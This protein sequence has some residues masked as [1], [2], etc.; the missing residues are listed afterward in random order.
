M[1]N[2]FRSIIIVL[3]RWLLIW[4]FILL[5]VLIDGMIFYKEV[6]AEIM[7]GILLKTAIAIVVI[8][9]ILLFSAFGRSHRHRGN[10]DHRYR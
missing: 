7:D 2:L 3:R 6:L 10:F 5:Y 4:T 8:A 9:G 1:E